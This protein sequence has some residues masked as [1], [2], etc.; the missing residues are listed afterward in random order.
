MEIHGAKLFYVD[1]YN[2]LNDMIQNPSKYGFTEFTKGC[3]GSGFIEVSILCNPLSI[4]CNNSSNHMF[5]DSVHPSQATYYSL[6]QAMR[7]SI[8][9]LI[10]QNI[11]I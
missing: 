10:K 4:V 9:S 8:D 2:P 1:I 7:P 5:W 3:C 6:F 11:S